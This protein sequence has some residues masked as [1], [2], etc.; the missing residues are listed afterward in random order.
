M[1]AKYGTIVDFYHQI[2]VKI[3]KFCDAIRDAIDGN[4]KLLGK[5]RDLTRLIHRCTCMISVDGL[6]SYMPAKTATP[7]TVAWQLVND[8]VSAE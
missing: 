3:L 8:A 2:E 5:S 6:T 7:R 4:R 1:Y